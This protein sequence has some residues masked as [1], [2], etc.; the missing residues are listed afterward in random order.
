MQ[1]ARIRQAAAKVRR[2]MNGHLWRAL[3][4]SDGAALSVHFSPDGKERDDDVVLSNTWRPELHE[5]CASIS[6]TL[7]ADAKIRFEEIIGDTP[8][9]AKMRVVSTS[10]T[11]YRAAIRADYRAATAGEKKPWWRFW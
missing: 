5:L 2:E 1:E 11:E 6:S 8:N 3:D 4:V 9:L 10:V 7:P